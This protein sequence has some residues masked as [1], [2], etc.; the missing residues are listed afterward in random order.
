MT[1][2]EE[3]IKV[4]EEYYTKHES[5]KGIMLVEE[6]MEGLTVFPPEFINE[7]SSVWE[8]VN[9]AIQDITRLVRK[10]SIEGLNRIFFN[11]DDY[12]IYIFSPFTD[13]SLIL[14][15]H[16]K[17]IDG[18]SITLINDIQDNFI[19]YL[20]KLLIPI[21]LTFIYP[22]WTVNTTA[23][24]NYLFPFLILSLNPLL[25]RP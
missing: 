9:D 7:L 20:N 14:F 1:K 25:L 18:S 16:D 2:T 23:Y 3:I 19:P 21:N 24:I 17:K 4:M 8:H 6:T 5:I 12:Q 22:K 15:S 11:M 13:L 10:Y